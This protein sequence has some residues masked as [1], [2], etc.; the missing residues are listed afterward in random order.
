MHSHIGPSPG[1]FPVGRGVTA[2]SFWLSVS[3]DV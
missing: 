1:P 3:A 2:F